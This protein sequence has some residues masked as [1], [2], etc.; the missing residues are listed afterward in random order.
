VGAALPVPSR[1]SIENQI[2]SAGSNLVMVNAGS[3]GFGPVRQG[4][5]AVTTLSADYAEAIREQVAGVRY[6]TPTLNTRTQ[7]VA[8]GANCNTQVQGANEAL[9]EI[10]AWRVQTGAFFTGH[11]VASGAKVAV[12][13]SGAQGR[14]A[15]SHRGVAIRVDDVRASRRRPPAGW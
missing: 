2:R 1:S 13:G 4:Q 11:D 5:G 10:R 3:G 12:L 6:L 15:Q 14:G 7:I 9:P 8:E